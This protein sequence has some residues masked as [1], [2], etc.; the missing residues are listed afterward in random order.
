MKNMKKYW[1]QIVGAVILVLVLILINK[2]SHNKSSATIDNDDLVSQANVLK[3]EVMAVYEGE[4]KLNYVLTMQDG[5]TTTLSADNRLLTLKSA[6]TSPIHFYFSYEGGRGY[7][8]NDYINNTIA[9]KVAII[10]RETMAHGANTWSVARSANSSWHV[11][12]FGEWL[13][14]IE[15]SNKDKNTATLY[16]ESF[17]VSKNGDLNA[18]SMKKMDTSDMKV[19]ATTTASSSMY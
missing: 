10:K 4:H 7:S 16:I 14:I 2:A 12:T 9:S 3:G 15:N 5:A 6:T 13:V 19:M 11:G 17:K 18:D 8:P 1:K